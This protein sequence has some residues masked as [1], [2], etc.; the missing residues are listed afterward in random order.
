MN[1]EASKTDE[2][3]QIENPTKVN[4]RNVQEPMGYDR[5]EDTGTDM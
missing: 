3:D 4:L 1:L 2:R 5:L